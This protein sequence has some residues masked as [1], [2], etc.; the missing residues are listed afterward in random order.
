MGFFVNIRSINGKLNDLIPLVEA[1][2]K[3]LSKY[4]NSNFK[5]V[6]RDPN[7]EMYESMASKSTINLILTS[8]FNSPKIKVIETKEPLIKEFLRLKEEFEYEFSNAHELVEKL[9]PKTIFD[10]DSSYAHWKN[11]LYFVSLSY[12]GLI[13]ELKD[14]QIKIKS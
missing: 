4:F 3:R 8:S 9:K 14:C 12:N 1:N 13:E 11:Q 10:D 7:Y 5:I 6:E 2:M